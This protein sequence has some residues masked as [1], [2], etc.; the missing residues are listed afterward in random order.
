[1]APGSTPGC[2]SGAAA[3]GCCRLPGCRP[4][5]QAPDPGCRVLAGA[6][7]R[8]GRGGPVRAGM[9]GG[10][11]CGKAGWPGGAQQGTAT[12]PGCQGRQER[13][14]PGGRGAPGRGPARPPHATR[15][16]RRPGGPR[17]RG[18]HPRGLA[19]RPP[20]SIQ[21][22]R[23]HHQ[24]PPQAHADQRTWPRRGASTANEHAA[25]PSSPP[26][27]RGGRHPGRL[28]PPGSRTR[29]PLAS[30]T[31]PLAGPALGTGCRCVV[32][33]PAVGRSGSL[34]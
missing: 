23:R 6:C 21:Q 31:R 7:A 25:V 15:P 17:R 22:V 29:A 14:G 33:G 27:A 34:C 16:P 24:R 20:G 3:G 1:M 26:R 10:R 18:S 8:A 5:R 11:A 30:G 2:S 9:G 12:G 32:P 28:S 4:A 19:P 13:A